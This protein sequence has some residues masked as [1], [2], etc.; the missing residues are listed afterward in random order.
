MKIKRVFLIVLDS[1]G[2]G[3]APDA[4]D[5][6]DEGTNTLKR[7]SKSTLFSANNLTRLGLSRIDGVDY[8]KG[9]HDEMAV[10]GRLKELSRGKDT[11]IGHW[12]LMGLISK[13]PM[14]T[15]PNG[16]PEEII[17]KFE[18]ATGRG[19]LC[20]KPYSG[21]DVIRDFGAE[22]ERSGK[23]IVYTSADSVFQIAAHEDIV[24]LSELYDACRKARE[25]LV[26]KD[27][28]GRVIARPFVGADGAYTRT[29]SRRDFSLAPPRKTLLNAISEAGLEVIA[30]GKIEDIFAG[31]GITKALHT[32][33][34]AEGM[35]ITAE[36]VK[37]DFSG[38]C[39][40]NLVDFDS[41]FGHRQDIDG[42]AAA[43]SEFDGWLGEFLPTLGPEDALIITADHGC[44]PGDD[45]TDHSREYVPLI[46]YGNAVKPENLG[47][48]DGFGRVAEIVADMLSVDFAP[49]KE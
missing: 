1:L 18:A 24:P 43:L 11:T 33:S 29:A 7:I 27:S 34:N 12:E 36:L 35:E 37:S 2:I 40:V 25:I 23:L 38:L 20:N 39:F 49:E 19:T 17:K 31:C 22:H 16:F 9:D 10:V 14:P 46:V 3:E 28:V 5:F 45:D 32:H 4:R 8:I 44:D 21:T 6:G 48:V 30:V 42:Y 41:K 15:Y 26:G 13:T 47:T